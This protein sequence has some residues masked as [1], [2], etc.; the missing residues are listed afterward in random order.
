MIE[1]VEYLMISKHSTTNN[2]VI[3][4]IF[5]GKVKEIALFE[6]FFQEDERF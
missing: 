2:S 4:D 1:T 3:S 5:S 6:I